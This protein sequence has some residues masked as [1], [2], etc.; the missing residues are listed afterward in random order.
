[1]GV[2]SRIS[3]L[4]WTLAA[5]SCLSPAFYATPSAAR[6]S[7]AFRASPLP[8]PAPLL[9]MVHATLRAAPRPTFDPALFEALEASPLVDLTPVVATPGDDRSFAIELLDPE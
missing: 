9:Q 8:Q 4:C 2:R 6:E 1:M 3:R 7:F 5:A